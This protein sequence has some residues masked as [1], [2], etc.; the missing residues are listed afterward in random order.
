MSDPAQ[1]AARREHLS[2]LLA[3]ERRRTRGG[4]A[5][6]VEAAARWIRE[7]GAAARPDCD[8]ALL[9]LARGP[10]T[11]VSHAAMQICGALNAREMLPE[12]LSLVR[13][14]D[15]RT[16]EAGR[17]T[18]VLDVLS[19]V[20]QWPGPA[21]EAYVVDLAQRFPAPEP[22]LGYHAIATLVTIDPEVGCRFLPACLT[23]DIRLQHPEGH[24]EQSL[25]PSPPEGA[26]WS[27]GRDGAPHYTEALIQHCLGTHGDITL[28]TILRNLKT[29]DPEARAYVVEAFTHALD[30]L[31]KA[32]ERHKVGRFERMKILEVVKHRMKID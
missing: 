17:R 11:L 1:I 24:G 3:P 32:S 19:L 25:P 21:A 12:L 4:E 9:D 27:F 28:M 6:V 14:L 30:R 13:R 5:A 20:R 23:E 16:P 22:F 7:Q 2:R 18:L 26:A 15:D 8:A 31:V 10:E 29:D